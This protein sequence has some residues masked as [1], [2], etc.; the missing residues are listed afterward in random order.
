MKKLEKKMIWKPASVTIEEIESIRKRLLERQEIYKK[1]G[2]D[3]AK[4]ISFVI[5]QLGKPRGPVLD[6]GTG[7][8]LAA[9]EIARRGTPVMT[10]DNSEDNLRKGYVTA[11]AASVDDMIEFYLADAADL[12][13]EDGRF[14]EIV[15]VNTLHHLKDISGVLREVSRLLS[16]GGS[17]VVGELTEEGFEILEGVMGREGRKHSRE[18][19]NTIFNATGLIRKFGLE[20][21]AQDERFQ[22]HVMLAR[23]R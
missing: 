12:P 8:G 22:Q 6:I 7:Q 5:D 15:M 19:Q 16:P 2:H 13:F 18:N 3:R 23:K 11:S 4:A 10:V 14:R 21:H 1:S 17:F 9:V 20:C